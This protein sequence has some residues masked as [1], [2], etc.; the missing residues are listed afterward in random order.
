MGRLLHNV[1]SLLL[2]CSVLFTTVLP[3][4]VCHAHATDEA[5]H[6]HEDADH[7]HRVPAHS[8]SHT[9]P[10]GDQHASTH[11]A[12][13]DG[14]SVAGDPD[15]SAEIRGAAAHV[16]YSICGVSF[17]LA[18]PGTADSHAPAGP[19]DQRGDHDAVVRCIDDFVTVSRVSLT[20]AFDVSIPCLVATTDRDAWRIIETQWRHRRTADQSC[21]CDRARRERSGVL[22]N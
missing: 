5:Q 3:P 22:Q 11:H 14:A 19:V 18:A 21:L 17:T 12:T 4:A 7:Q 8:H 1:L 13:A 20:S 9:H 16:H 2:C 15:G 6:S 10:H